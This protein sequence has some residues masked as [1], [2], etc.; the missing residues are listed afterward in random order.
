[1]KTKFV[2]INDIYRVNIN[3]IFSLEKRAKDNSE[4]Y[5]RWWE[6]YNYYMN[7]YDEQEIEIWDD[8]YNSIDITDETNETI[9]K[10][11]IR[12]SAPINPTSEEKTKWDEFKK[13]YIYTIIGKCPEFWT[14]E[15]WIILSTGLKVEI[16][17]DKFEYI[18]KVIDELENGD[19]SEL[20]DNI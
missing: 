10:F 13:K 14:Y 20:N 9:D 6:D 18:N 5:N 4:I 16:A 1:M 11:P 19:I 12:Y 7:L 17:K 3:A 8:R 15:Y 2:W